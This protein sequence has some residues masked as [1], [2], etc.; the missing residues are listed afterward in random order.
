MAPE[1]GV[2]YVT[3]LIPNFALTSLH[4][5]LARRR[6]KSPD[7]QNLQLNLLKLQLVWC[8]T[9]AELQRLNP[10]TPERSLDTQDR[11]L[12]HYNKTAVIF[13]ALCAAISWLGFFFQL[14]M[15]ASLRYLASPRNERFLRA[16]R[17]TQTPDLTVTEISEI[18]EQLQSLTGQQ[19]PV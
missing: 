11:D 5:W 1:L 6:A 14:L 16:S 8:E 10:P 4:L 12:E 18:L 13:G 9:K 7:T 17:L 2:A 15:M 3:G 19:L